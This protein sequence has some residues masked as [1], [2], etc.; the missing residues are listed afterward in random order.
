MK[1]LSLWQPWATLIAIGA[2][3]IETRHWSTSYRG[4]IAIHAAKL[5]NGGLKLT[6]NEQPFRDALSGA[7]IRYAASERR[8]WYHV[9]A[10]NYA[11]GLPF[12]AIVAVADLVD[13][14]P[15]ERIVSEGWLA[16]KVGANG[17]PYW[18]PGR[19]EEQFGNYE[20]RRFGLLLDHITPLAQ[21][22]SWRGQQGL[23]TLT[24]DEVRRIR[25]E[26]AA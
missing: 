6:V 15:T 11:G 3:R 22:L 20:P 19:H 1:A 18:T 8:H 12:G 7:G 2:K 23:W 14:L 26:L 13:V 10:F 16:P 25:L 24:A 4:P 17:V 21:P 9:A 5:W